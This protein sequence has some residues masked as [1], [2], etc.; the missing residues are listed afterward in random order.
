MKSYFSP[1]RIA[2]GLRIYGLMSF[3]I[4]VLTMLPDFVVNLQF[5]WHYD[6]PGIISLLQYFLNAAI[7]VFLLFGAAIALENIVRIRDILK[8]AFAPEKAAE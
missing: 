7:K 6:S 4:F 3:A 5:E 2:T 8:E 1:S